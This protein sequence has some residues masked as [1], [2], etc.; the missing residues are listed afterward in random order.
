MPGKLIAFILTLLVIVLFIFMNHDNSSDIRLWF[1]EKGLYEDVPIYL[2][3]FFMYLLG[4]I[5]VIPFSIGRRIKKS[6]KKKP[7]DKPKGKSKETPEN[8][9]E[10]SFEVPADKPR[11]KQR[12]MG[13]KKDRKKDEKEPKTY[14]EKEDEV[15]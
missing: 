4:V 12:P 13:R 7:A 10:N 9:E 15:K 1:G 2:S 6:V 8:E 11:K 3:F 14:K 5:S